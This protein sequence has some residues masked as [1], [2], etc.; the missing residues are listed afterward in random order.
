MVP[1]VER[2]SGQEWTVQQAVNFGHGAGGGKQKNQNRDQ[3]EAAFPGR[4]GF[5]HGTPF[6]P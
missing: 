4:Y 3:V 1:A 2:P 5:I 6:A